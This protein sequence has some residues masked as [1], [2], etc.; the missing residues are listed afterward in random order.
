MAN[1]VTLFSVDETW[2][3]QIS[4]FKT[5]LF[6]YNAIGTSVDVWHREQVGGNVWGAAPHTDWVAKAASSISITNAYTGVIGTAVGT[7]HQSEVNVAHSELKIWSVG[8]SISFD[9]TASP[10]GPGDPNL[11]G[12]APSFEVRSVTGNASVSLPG[13]PRPLSGTTSAS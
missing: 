12:G 3:V 13:Q 5:N 8:I 4:S 10:G 11:P 7:Q 6:F 1:Q 2:K 9:A